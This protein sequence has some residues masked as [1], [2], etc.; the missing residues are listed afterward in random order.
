MKTLV[1]RRAARHVLF[2]VAVEVID[3]LIQLPNHFANG[4]PLYLW[5]LLLVQLPASLICV[6]SLVYGLLPKV[7]ARRPLAWL[8][9]LLWVAGSCVFVSALSSFYDRVLNPT[10][11]GQAPPPYPFIWHMEL[12]RIRVSFLVLLVTAGVF[13]GYKVI[14]HWRE[15][16]VLH[17]QLLQRKL[18]TEL[19]LLKAQLQPVFLFN[20]LGTLHALTTQKSPESPAAVLHLSALL[21]Y[22]LYES[23]L[24]AVPLAEEVELLRHYV[25]LEQL[26]LGPDVEVS[27]S[28]NGALERHS[29]APLLLLPFVE[30]A[31]RLVTETAQ[32][33]PWL[34]L[35]LVAKRHS[36][37]FKVI[38]S[39]PPDANSDNAALHSV[40]QRLARLYPDQHELKITADPDSLLITL[41]LRPSAPALEGALP[42][43]MSLISDP[44]L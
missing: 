22:L 16:Q 42:P 5:G 17:Q 36:L 11:L 19:E 33:C 39:R 6:Y 2:W 44:M 26:R 38:S 28:F 13:V 9:L 24:P 30:N 40:H 20:T 10:W 37:T 35:D 15:Q 23:Q 32:D 21:R 7:L 27:L 29:I 3:L 34:S 18:Q 41:H 12:L 1:E 8:W 4:E 14:G 25:A 43:S 31:F